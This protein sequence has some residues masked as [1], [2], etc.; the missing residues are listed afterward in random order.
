MLKNTEKKEEIKVY[1]QR[2]LVLFVYFSHLMGT[3]I[4]WMTVGSIAD[5]AECYYGVN[6]FWINSLAYVFLVMYTLLFA[7]ATYFLKRFGLRWTAILGGCF[8]AAGAW[9]RFAAAGKQT[10][11]EERSPFLCI[12]IACMQTR[13]IFGS[14]YWVKRFRQLLMYLNGVLLRFCLLSGFHRMRGH[15]Q[16]L[17]L[18]LRLHR[19]TSFQHCKRHCCIL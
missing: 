18:V 5:I 8:N 19:L 1:W 10:A 2:W 12:F 17:L 6:V 16:P 14:Y 13:T 4:A 11:L 9:L 3:N 15:L 7:G